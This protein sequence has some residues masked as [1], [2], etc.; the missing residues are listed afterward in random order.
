M[1]NRHD[2]YQFAAVFHRLFL[3]ILIAKNAQVFSQE[4]V[5]SENNLRSTSVLSR[6]I[7][8]ETTQS[9]RNL[10]SIRADIQEVID[11]AGKPIT[12]N[13]S[14]VSGP[15]LRLR[16]EFAFSLPD[17]ATGSMLEVCDGQTLYSY[18]RLGDSA[19]CT[20]REVRKILN[21]AHV[22]GV[23]LLSDRSNDLGLGGL[24]GLIASLQNSMDFENPERMTIEGHE[25]VVLAGSWNKEFLARWNDKKPIPAGIPDAV[26]VWIRRDVNF[27]VRF[28]YSKRNRNGE[29][30][31]QVQIEFRNVRFNERV[32]EKEFLYIPREDLV[33]EDTTRRYIEQIIR[34]SESRQSES[35]KNEPRKSSA[36]R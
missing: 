33:P 9:L 11:L 30:Q 5:A 17:A 2:H 24:P 26:K 21:A 6:Q 8:S 35:G 7:L 15:E 19:R 28:V 18:L 16:I 12:L 4:P 3:A 31:P 14:Y 13:G 32:D 25:L 22:H 20:R 29:S 34:Q 27:P 1:S 10:K 36:S 23:D